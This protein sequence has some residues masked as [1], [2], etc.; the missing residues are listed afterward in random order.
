MSCQGRLSGDPD[1]ITTFNE[2]YTTMATGPDSDSPPDTATSSAPQLPKVF[3]QQPTKDL[4][5]RRPG[6]YKKHRQGMCPEALQ[7]LLEITDEK[8]NDVEK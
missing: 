1:M 5:I 3:Q 6:S 8:W 4:P 7:K 2:L